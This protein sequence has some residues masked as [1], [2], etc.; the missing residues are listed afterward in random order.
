[1]NRKNFFKKGLLGVVG[2]VVG[3]IKLKVEEMKKEMKLIYDKLM[4]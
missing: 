3:I 2:L 4:D 1:M